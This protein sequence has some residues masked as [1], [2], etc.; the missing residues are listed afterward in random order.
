VEVTR[1]EIF[2]R[3]TAERDRQD[4]KYGPSSLANCEPGAKLA[5]VVEEIGEVARAMVDAKGNVSENLRDELTQ[6]AACC[7][8]WLESLP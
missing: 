8:A 1:S 4:A 3:I 7:V 5:I 6:V 2:I